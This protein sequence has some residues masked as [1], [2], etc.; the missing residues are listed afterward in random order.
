MRPQ[1][2]DAPTKVSRTG[3]KRLACNSVQ[4]NLG[5]VTAHP[6]GQRESASN[7]QRFPSAAGTSSRSSA[8]AEPQKVTGY[9]SRQPFMVAER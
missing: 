6:T 9:S 5:V 4:L 7:T 3:S 1:G 8:T 2:A